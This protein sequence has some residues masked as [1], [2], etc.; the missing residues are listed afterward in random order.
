MA[1][2]L[3]VLKPR[4]PVEPQELI[5][6]LDPLVKRL[7]AEVEHRTAAHLSAMLRDASDNLR[8]Q[9]FADVQAQSCGPVLEL[10]LM[11]REPMGRGAPL[12]RG[13]FGQLLELVEETIPSV[14]VTFRSDRDGPLPGGI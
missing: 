9:L 13:R 3:V 14:Q 2:F 7:M 5:S 11:S 1:R 12:T 6:A 8:L 10:V 4:N